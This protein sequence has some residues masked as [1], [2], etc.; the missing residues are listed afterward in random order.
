[1]MSPA[2]KAIC[3]LSEQLAEDCSWDE[4]MYGLYVRQKIQ[5]GLA[6]LEQGLVVNRDDVF[7]EYE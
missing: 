2:K 4:A 7:Q 3:D 1:M 5:Q 6:E